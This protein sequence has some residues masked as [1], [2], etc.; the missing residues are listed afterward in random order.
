MIVVSNAS[1]LISLAKINLLRV[2]EQL[3]GT[4]FITEQVSAE[5]TTAG[6]GAQEIAQERWIQTVPLTDPALLTQWRSQYRLGLGE[7]ST[8]LLAKE[9]SSDLAIIDERKARQ[10]ARSEGVAVVG[11]VGILEE[12]Y[13]RKLIT[14]LRAA[15]QNLLATG[16]YLDRWM[17]NQSLSSFQLPPL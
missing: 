3:F 9:R 15:Y 14:D 2:L 17:L 1:P 11:T 10:V 7:L 6:S 5:A 16:T 13:R 4:V 12:A 8:I